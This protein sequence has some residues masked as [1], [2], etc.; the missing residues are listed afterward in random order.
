V[1]GL[2]LAVS[3][4]V[5]AACAT[6]H[7]SV[8][9]DPLAVLKLAA[10]RSVATSSATLTGAMFNEGK[11]VV[12]LSGAIDLH[13]RADSITL[14]PGP[15]GG[16]YPSYEARFVG[17]WSYVE[18]DSAVRH[19]PTLRSGTTWIAFQ[20]WPGSLPVPDRSLPPSFPIDAVHLPIRQPKIAA[21]F[22][23]PAGTNPRRVSVRFLN[24]EYS[25]SNYTYSIDSRGLL[26][27]LVISDPTT[28]HRLETF[29]FTYGASAPS[30]VA[31]TSGV[32]RLAPGERLYPP[33]TTAP[34]S[35]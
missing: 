24:G 15:G 31:P 20:Q 14:K 4:V 21:S 18:I 11:Q 19:P 32:Q 6:S 5:F 3:L 9:S 28:G 25:A 30:I 33:K 8:A 27:A 17:G 12:L 16:S 10:Q 2:A 26:V 23:D 35:G 7:K 29:D 1:K 34:T 22:I 13:Q